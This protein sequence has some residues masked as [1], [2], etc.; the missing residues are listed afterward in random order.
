MRDHS[1][2]VGFGSEPCP[3]LP[4]AAVTVVTS[5]PADLEL[6]A[7]GA[8]PRALSEWVTTFHLVMVVIDPYTDQSAW[9]LPTANRVLSTFRG[10]DCRVAW[11][12]TADETDAKAFLGPL[13]TEVLTLCDPNR[14]AVKA[15]GLDSLPALVHVRQDLAVVGAAQGWNPHEWQ[16]V[17]DNLGT[18]MSWSK[19]V[20]PAPGDPTPFS[21]SPAV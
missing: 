10:A 21:G 5:A 19:P 11:L 1:E 2:S 12:V 15:L 13:A 14:V 3:A 9:I 17:T 18:L 16:Q 20:L 8:E 6:A 4:S 7:L